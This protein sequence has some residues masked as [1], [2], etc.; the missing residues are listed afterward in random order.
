MRTRPATTTAILIGALA[1]V[2]LS[3]L[4]AW[5]AGRSPAGGMVA[6]VRPI[7]PLQVAVRARIRASA[8]GDTKLDCVYAAN[9]EREL[10]R[11]EA[12]VRHRVDCVEVYDNESQT[13]AQWE[14][15]WFLNDQPGYAWA[16]WATARGTHRELVFDK[17][18]IPTSL[19]QTAWRAACARGA[20]TARARALARNLVAAGLSRTIIRLA[21]EMN[22]T[23]TIDNVGATR[24]QMRAWAACWRRTV[25]AM[26]EVPGALFRIDF[27]INAAVRPIPLREF[28]PGNRTVDIVG[29]DAYDQG[30]GPAEDRWQTIVERPD[31]LRDVIAFAHAHHKP[32]SIPEWGLAG[33]ANGEGGGNDPSYVKGIARIVR[34]DDVAYQSYFFNYDYAAQLAH[35]AQ[36]LRLYRQLFGG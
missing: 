24:G 32:L 31:G 7:P 16:R 8:A 29:I 9:S 17:S 20:F 35:D 27:S 36:S 34:D 19:A 3:V 11:F 6:A 21:G 10:G 1:A 33:A 18:L 28:Y 12:L 13:W 4:P 22:G 15:P 25:L 2:L 30:V 23:W 26:R 14:H 5:A